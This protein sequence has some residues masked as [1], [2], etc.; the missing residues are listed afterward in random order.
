VVFVLLAATCVAVAAGEPTETLPGEPA[1]HQVVAELET[2][3]RHAV[4][5]FEQMDATGVLAHIS[6]RYRTGPL[7]KPAVHQQLLTIFAAHETLRARVRIDEV[8]MIGDRAWVYSSGDVSGRLRLLGTPVVLWSWTRAPEVAWR[9][10]GRWRL[11][12]DQ[13]P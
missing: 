8:R 10:D 3:L 2:T 1:P 9:E 5:R 13:Q 6:D 12:G 11:I 7:T 4:G